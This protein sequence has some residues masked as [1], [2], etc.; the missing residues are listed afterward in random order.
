MR[1]EEALAADEEVQEWLTGEERGLDVETVLGAR[2]GVVVDPDP[3][4]EM[5]A[6]WVSIP[7][8]GL[9]GEVLKIR[10]RKRP[11]SQDKNK[12]MDVSHSF[13]RLYGVADVASDAD[14]ICI[15][16]GEFDKLILNQC[17]LPAVAL[18]GGTAW[19][20]HYRKVLAGFDEI[21][22][23]GDPDPT[24]KK[25]N[26]AVRQSLRQAKPIKLNADVTDEYLA[27]GPDYIR[28]LV[29]A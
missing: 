12:Y 4:H 9:N 27:N 21:F 26:Q 5:F 2:L 16:E 19:K 13:P 6:G 20:P 3:D 14:F 7:Y 11:G 15:T 23:F 18:P 22:V 17:G 8:L 10:F 29:D 24:G 1:Y 25:L 28:E